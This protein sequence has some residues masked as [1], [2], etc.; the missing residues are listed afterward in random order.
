[1]A[2]KQSK[3]SSKLAKN[4]TFL[5]EGI[6]AD[7]RLIRGESSAISLSLV[8][9]N[10]KQQ[11]IIP[12]KIKKKAPALFAPRQ[13]KIKSADV[14]AFT[15]QIA[16][17]LKAGV[18]IVQA[19]EIIGK[20]QPNPAFKEIILNIK[21]DIET[22]NTLKDALS[23]YPKYFN[24]LF[25]N[26]VHAGE[27]AG[28]LESMLQRIATYKEKIESIK[29]K[30]KK[31]LFYPIAI[32]AVAIIVT[33][34][35]LLYVVPQFENLFK[36]FGAELPL[37]TRMVLR[38]SEL[39][40]QYWWVV[41][42]GTVGLV[43]GFLHFL[44]TS[45]SFAYLVD[46]LQLRLPVFGKILKN[47][48]IARFARTLSITFSAG[49]PLVDA[50]DCVSTTVG[51]RIYRDGVISVKEDVATGIQIQAAM[52]T[53]QLFPSMV[54]QMVAIGEESGAID[55]MLSKIADFYEESVDNAVDGL[56]SLLEPLIMAVLGLLIGGLIAAMYL[57]IFQLGSLV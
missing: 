13:K 20:G 48:A 11:G 22:G 16:T 42:G 9:A 6:N 15:R 7:G 56:S 4:Q 36:G 38:L 14:T 12:K 34:V 21:A 35:L 49:L 2:K 5:W 37:F 45:E 52:N 41:I 8:K 31:A 46:K 24:N 51:N 29:R 50:L 26:L 19:M 44:K 28:E 43:M 47:A 55:E 32:M 33:F 3:N 53:T 10:L 18:P 17:L 40:Q 30:I 25:C 54:V 27:Q 57:P 39:V 23:K 1:M